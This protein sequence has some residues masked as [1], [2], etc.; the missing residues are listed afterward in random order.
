MACQERL[1]D[2]YEGGRC[3]QGVCSSERESSR[4]I[5]SEI[6]LGVELVQQLGEQF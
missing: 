2:V 4:L 6:L 5:G 1:Q 3:G